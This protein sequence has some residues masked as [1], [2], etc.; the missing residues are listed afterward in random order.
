[1]SKISNLH[2]FYINNLK[3]GSLSSNTKLTFLFIKQG[4]NYRVTGKS[5]LNEK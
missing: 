1:M 5:K 2:P 4:S 3:M